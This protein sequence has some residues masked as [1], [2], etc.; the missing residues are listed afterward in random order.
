MAV[1]CIL[2]FIAWIVRER[3]AKSPL[4]DLSLFLDRNFAIGCLLVGLFGACVYGCLLYTSTR[5][6]KRLGVRD[7]V[8]NQHGCR[9]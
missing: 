1:A 9:E 6:R 2:G 4:V 8:H 3:V 7:A 5:Q